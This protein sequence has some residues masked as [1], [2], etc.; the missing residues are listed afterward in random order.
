MKVLIIDD[1]EGTAATLQKRFESMGH[2]ADYISDVYQAVEMCKTDEIEQY[3]FFIIDLYL[4]G[5]NGID[6]FRMLNEKSLGGK[7]VFITGCNG[8]TDIFKIALQTNRPLVMKKFNSKQLIK[9]L[10]DG[11]TSEWATQLMMSKGVSK[12]SILSI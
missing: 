3:D 10:V 8:T 4:N 5:V 11:S 9:S 7:V 6:I 12:E 1:Y 2:E